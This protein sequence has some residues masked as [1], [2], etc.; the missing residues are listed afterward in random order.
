MVRFTPDQLAALD[1]MFI[2]GVHSMSQEEEEVFAD[3]HG[4][5]PSRQSINDPRK[6]HGG[7]RVNVW[8]QEQRSRPKPAALAR[9]QALASQLGMIEN[10]FIRQTILI[11]L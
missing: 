4:I 3:L 7:W 11:L 8:L 9:R 5:E 2:S 10:M 1:A 6:S